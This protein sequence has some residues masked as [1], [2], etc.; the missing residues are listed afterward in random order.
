MGNVG[1][2]LIV[3]VVGHKVFHGIV[4]EKFLELRAQLGSQR[5]VMGQ[6]Q[7]GTLD[8]LNHLGHG[9]GLA[10]ARNAQKHLFLN[11]IV[12]AVHQCLNGSRLI[13]GR[14]IFTYHM[15]LSHDEPPGKLSDILLYHK[16]FYLQTIKKGHTIVCPKKWSGR[17][18]S[19]SLP[20]PW[21]GGALPDELRP[22]FRMQELL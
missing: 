20:P 22:H 14:L 6:H 3:V 12:Q 5:L 1:F 13:A 16:S 15:K 4:R 21:Q 9:I 11:T 10:A 19:N 7:S 18:G 8:G 2:R 17:R